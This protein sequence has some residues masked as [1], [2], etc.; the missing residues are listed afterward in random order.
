MTFATAPQLATARHLQPSN[1]HSSRV[2]KT[3]AVITITRRKRLGLLAH[4]NTKSTG[5]I[6]KVN[7]MDSW[8][9]AN[10]TGQ[11]RAV[12]STVHLHITFRYRPGPGHTRL[13]AL[14]KFKSPA[15]PRLI[16]VT[17][18]PATSCGLAAELFQRI[19]GLALNVIQPLTVLCRRRS[20][21]C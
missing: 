15:S 11:S 17:A 9:D 18:T 21:Q 1:I 10:N 6:C 2:L 3:P 13:Q 4:H 14:C 12:S 5:I 19:A 16:A 20:A 7:P 8:Y